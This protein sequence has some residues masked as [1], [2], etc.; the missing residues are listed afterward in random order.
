[1]STRQAG[2][3]EEEE[4]DIYQKQSS[5]RVRELGVSNRVTDTVYK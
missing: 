4:E 1:M 2:L 3:V 5:P